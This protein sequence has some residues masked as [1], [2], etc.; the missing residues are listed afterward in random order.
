[1]PNRDW[2]SLASVIKVDSVDN[3]QNVGGEKE[4]RAP[5]PKQ[6]G[7]GQCDD[8]PNGE[9]DAADHETKLVDPEQVEDDHIDDK[10]DADDDRNG[11]SGIR[12]FVSLL[13]ICKKFHHPNNVEDKI[14]GD[15]NGDDDRESELDGVLVEWSFARWSTLA[16]AV[17][18]GS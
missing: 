9:K 1:M 12:H 13:I 8:E 5:V 11:P 3:Q 6:F 16:K 18:S 10:E 2:A 4:P 14:Q 17:H 7:D 15:Q